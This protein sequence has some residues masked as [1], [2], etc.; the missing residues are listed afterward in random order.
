MLLLGELSMTS[1]VS[2]GMRS[3]FHVII[4]SNSGVVW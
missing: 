3:V 4:N 2:P 1:K